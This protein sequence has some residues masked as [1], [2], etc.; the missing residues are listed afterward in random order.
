MRAG[1]IER[2]RAGDDAVEIVGEALCQRE[3]LAAALRAAFV[4]G[5]G[6]AR[7]RNKCARSVLAVSAVTCSERKPKSRS[8]CRLRAKLAPGSEAAE[9]PVS[10]AAVTKPA[11]R[12]RARLADAAGGFERSRRPSRRCR[13]CRS[14]VFQAVGRLT[15]ILISGCDHRDGRGSAR[16]RW[17]SRDDAGR[18]D[19][20]EVVTGKAQ[21]FTACHGG[22]G[23]GGGSGP[24]AELNIAATLAV[25][26]GRAGKDEAQESHS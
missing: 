14:G 19:H 1:L 18:A 7:R 4:V 13:T 26:S 6:R 24:I 12:P 15:S 3:A 9:C 20:G 23:R 10:V 2:G 25:E 22:L 8:F 17:G 16:E 5:L 11:F 21:Q